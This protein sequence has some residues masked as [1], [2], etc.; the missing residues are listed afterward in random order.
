[1][2]AHSNLLFIRIENRRRSL[3]FKDQFGA[4][5]AVHCLP[6]EL[7]SF[8]YEVVIL[9]TA[10]SSAEKESVRCPAA[11]RRVNC[12]AP[13]STERISA[14]R[15]FEIPI[16]LDEDILRSGIKRSRRCR[17]SS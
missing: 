8:G 15:S 4:F 10:H 3:N 1:M 5:S 7:F 16:D 17:D 9:T 6:P 14:R 11:V 13:A 2:Q 12:S